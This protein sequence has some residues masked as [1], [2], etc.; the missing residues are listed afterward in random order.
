MSNKLNNIQ[1]R[2]TD[3]QVKTILK[4]GKILED[5]TGQ[6]I[7]RSEAIRRLSYERGKEIIK[8]NKTD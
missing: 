5:E 4:A 6:R 2:M 7:S 3:Q 1:I 8:N